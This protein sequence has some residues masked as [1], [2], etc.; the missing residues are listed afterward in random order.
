MARPVGA[1]RLRRELEEH[2]RE[3]GIPYGV[4]TAG[5]F[6]VAYG[7]ATTYLRPRALRGK[8]VVR[9]WAVTNVDLDM[10]DELTRFLVTENAKLALGGFEIDGSGKVAFSHTLLGDY[11]QRAE[12]AVALAAVATTADRYAG[13]IKS[14]FGGKLF[15]EA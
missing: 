5:D 4:D 3:M 13:E 12:L 9:I 15:G 10:S 7:N 14:R 8:T 6:E 11:L 2:L 1:E